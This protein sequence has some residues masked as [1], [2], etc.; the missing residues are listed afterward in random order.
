MQSRNSAYATKDDLERLER[1]FDQVIRNLEDI[2]LQSSNG[3]QTPPRAQMRPEPR[4][5]PVQEAEV[6]SAFVQRVESELVNSNE[7]PDPDEEL[8][9]EDEDAITRRLQAETKA[10]TRTKKRD[11][12]AE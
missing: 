2:M 3:P 4:P 1:K 6:G 5:E 12:K 10:A 8:K 9:S 7:L 11:S